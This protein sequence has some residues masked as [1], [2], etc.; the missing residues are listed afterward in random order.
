[1][2]KAAGELLVDDQNPTENGPGGKLAEKR[3]GRKSVQIKKQKL[4][5][6]IKAVAPFSRSILSTLPG[7]FQERR[8]FCPRRNYGLQTL[9]LYSSE[10]R[11]EKSKLL[12]MVP[13][14]RSGETF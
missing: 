8:S 2:P 3:K 6:G 7:S 5:G 11:G 13:R 4:R 14:K 12:P 10:W 9:A 1:M